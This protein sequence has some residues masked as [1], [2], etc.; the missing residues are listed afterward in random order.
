MKTKSKSWG[1][2]LGEEMLA[3]GKTGIKMGADFTN[4]GI[5]MTGAGTKVTMIPKSLESDL[6]KLAKKGQKR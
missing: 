5:G 2:L 1:Q 6:M 3:F 4:T